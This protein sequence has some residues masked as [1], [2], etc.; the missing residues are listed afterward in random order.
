PACSLHSWIYHRACAAS[1]WPSGA[2]PAS[3]PPEVAVGLE[4]SCVRWADGEVRCF[5]QGAHGQL[6]TSLPPLVAL[7]AG[8][9]TTCGIDEAGA[10]V[11]FGHNHRG[12]LG[13]GT[14]EDSAIPR[15]VSGLPPAVEISVGFAHACARSEDGTVCCWG[16]NG[17]GQ[18]DPSSA[19]AD[20]RAP[21][22]RAL[23]ARR[24]VAGFDTTCT[25]DGADGLSC[26]GAHEVEASGARDVAI[27]ADHVCV[28]SADA[29]TCH[30]AEPGG[31]GEPLEAPLVL[32]F[33]GGALAAGAIDHVCVTDR[34]GALFCFGKND[35]GQA[36]DGTF[37]SRHAPAPVRF[38]P[39]PITSAGV[40]DRHTCAVAEGRPFCWGW[41]DEG[42]LGEDG[43]VPSLDPVE[44]TRNP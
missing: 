40:G 38:L 15:R 17:N 39:T 12:Q 11:C 16:W 43:R 2:A 32:P 30:G 9:N 5:G 44:V 27:G 7:D 18:S 23:D 13:D 26:F 41:N 14:Y 10:V 28:L 24:V 29:V 33:E 20:V 3:P 6:G 4:H 31:A 19:E 8:G 22:C 1:S 37:V 42:Q 34:A 36:G 25:I 35:H 21:A